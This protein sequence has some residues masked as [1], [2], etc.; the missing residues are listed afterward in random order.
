VAD[1]GYGSVLALALLFGAVLLMGT[2]VDIVRL[3]HEWRRADHIATVAAETGAGWV[4][5]EPLYEGVVVIDDRA[6]SEAALG[7]ARTAGFSAEVVA[8]ATQVCV[9]VS[10]TVEPRLGR[11]LGLVAHHP[12]VT[13]CGSPRQG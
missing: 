13:A 11:L 10:A 9:A 2:V 12:T 4:Q 6:A 3:V 8:N 7:V 5:P 1:R